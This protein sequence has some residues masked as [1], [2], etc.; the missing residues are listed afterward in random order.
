M[1]APAVPCAVGLDFGTTNT[2]AARAGSGGGA[3]SLVRLD[4]A[5]GAVFRTAL[6]FWHDEDVRGGLA[7]EAGPG[8]IREY[9][10]FPTDSR[11]LQ[12]FKSTAASRS[13]DTAPVFEK[14]FRFEELGRL[15]LDKLAGHAGGA[16]DRLDRV[17]VG[18][19]VT[20]AGSRPDEALARQRYDAM[21]AGFAR[22]VHYVY[23]PLA[24]AFAYAAT[25]SE[26]TTLLVADFGGGTSDFSVVRIAEPG[27]AQR[28]VPLGHA[29]IGIAGDRFDARI[30]DKLVLPF[31]GK[32][33]QY[34]SFDKILDI[35]GGYFADLADWSK[36]AL[37]RNR[38]TLAELETLRRAAIDPEPIARMIALIE[39]ELGFP[40]YDAVGRLKRAL[41]VDQ[42]AQF[43]FR[44]GDVVIEGEVS[45][46]EFEGWIA[47]DVARMAEA[48]D[49]ALAEAGVG[50]G[51]I[52][53]V[54]LTGG[55]SLVPAV[56]AIFTERFGADRIGTGGELTSIADGL[57]R[58]AGQDDVTTWTA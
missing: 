30:V 46:A 8:A 36:L 52:D 42:S 9:L 1:T 27:A 49:R 23:E 54:F 7:A 38:R 18:R 58:I 39:D 19:P 26:P 11:F 32:G 17:V 53:W 21:F 15:F 37:M 12:S 5:E 41:T 6:C 25:L 24:A 29:G 13:F 2:V 57:A 34:R 51:E 3:P 48:L 50:E 40:L 28:C 33:G 44:G 16:L 55:T 56:R 20:Y 45:R 14:R 31:L 10:E 43:S 22:E 35:P 47:A 4:A